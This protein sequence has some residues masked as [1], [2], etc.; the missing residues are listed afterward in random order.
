[1]EP[2]QESEQAEHV[3]SRAHDLSRVVRVGGIDRDGGFVEVGLVGGPVPGVLGPGGA[4]TGSGRGP[5]A[6]G[7]GDGDV[8]GVGVVDFADQFGSDLVAGAEDCEG[9]LGG[10]GC[11]LR[12]AILPDDAADFRWEAGKGAER[13][14][15]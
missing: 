14:A 11:W 3:R 2:R 9:V 5:G 13:G 1:M 15:G 12:P 10:E 8:E 7:G 6:L 4:E